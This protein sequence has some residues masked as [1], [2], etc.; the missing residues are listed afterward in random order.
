MREPKDLGEYSSA[1]EVAAELRKFAD[2]VETGGEL[3]RVKYRLKI[4][5]WH[6]DYMRTEETLTKAQRERLPR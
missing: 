1:K 5:V 6:P 3:E 2:S 4:W